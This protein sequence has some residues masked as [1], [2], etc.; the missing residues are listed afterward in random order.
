MLELGWYGA[1]WLGL[2]LVVLVRTGAPCDHLG[3]VSFFSWLLSYTLLFGESLQTAHLKP[4]LGS[5]D[6]PHHSYSCL[7]CWL[8]SSGVWQRGG[9]GPC[10]GPRQL[11]KAQ[12]C[13]P[14]SSSN[15]LLGG[16]GG[17]WAGSPVIPSI[18]AWTSQNMGERPL[19]PSAGWVPC[20]TVWLMAN[21]FLMADSVQL[22]SI[23]LSK[24]AN[25]RIKKSIFACD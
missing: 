22:N 5:Y 10:T 25:S 3:R 9:A 15:A 16:E 1:S 23:C 17:G 24:A 2:A 14:F 4:R 18:P 8:S 12:P 11:L 13:T 19:F 21:C 6:G 7:W 20:W